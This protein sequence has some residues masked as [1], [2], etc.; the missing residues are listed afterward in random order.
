MFG[1]WGKIK[2]QFKVKVNCVKLGDTQSELLTMAETH[3]TC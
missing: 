1:M 3:D 2:V